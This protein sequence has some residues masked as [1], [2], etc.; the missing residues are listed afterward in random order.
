M[1]MATMATC[2]PS[3]LTWTGGKH[4]AAKRIV[5]AFP[6]AHTYG[7]Y[8]EVFGG[9]AHVLMQRSPQ[10]HIEVFNDLN[11]D[12]IRFWLVA[13]DQPEA[14]QQRVDT[15][16]F[17]RTVYER[18][19]KNL[20]EHEPMDDL[21][22]AARWFYVLRSTFS[23]SPNFSKGWGYTIS[24]G[25]YKAHSLRTATALLTSIAARF[26]LV[27]IEHQDFEK[28][29]KVYE[30]PQTLFYCDPP[31]IG[32]ESY[33]AFDGMPPFTEQDHHRLAALLNATPALV[34]LS[35]YAHPW[36]ETLY[37]LPKWRRMTWMQPKA[38]ERTRGTRQ[39]G[40]E[41][42][43]MNYAETFGGLWHDDLHCA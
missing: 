9:A 31:Y 43:L 3:P 12:L 19:R 8:V 2:L 22:R 32:Y 16:P 13:R 11:D 39:Q 33:Y 4:A 17:S 36:L 10:T 15:L 23:G 29:I 30:T 25:N 1:S 41:V 5:A 27:Q 28:I 37:P 38:A 26:R 20:N 34:A 42:L 35:Y 7:T 18:Y 21:E 6:P 24:E 14:L 40:Q